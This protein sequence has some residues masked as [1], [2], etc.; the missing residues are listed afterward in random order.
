M[1]NIT[2]LSWITYALI[3]SGYIV[4]L[5]SPQASVVGYSC[6]VVGLFSL[7]V[8]QLVPLTRQTEV[9]LS[10]F[11]P[12]IPIIVVLGITSWLLAINIKFSNELQKGNVTDEYKTFNTI[13]F[14]LMLVQLV[15]LKMNVL[16]Y[17][18]AMV[19]FVASFQ[20]LVV[21]VMQMNLEYFVT[22]G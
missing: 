11:I 7:I 9:S 18:S 5:A 19:A 1:K 21:F 13:N 12:Y 15:I 8:L 17:K 20:L 3:I 2:Y 10:M 14:V 6:V 4:S 22:D 16:E